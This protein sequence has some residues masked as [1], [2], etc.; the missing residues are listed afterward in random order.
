MFMRT[1]TFA[2]VGLLA[3]A[4][5]LTACGDADDPTV[6]S[7]DD[8]ASASQAQFND[9]DVA[10]VSGMVPHHTQ[11]VEM[12]DMILEQDSS[13]PVAVLA[14]KIKSAQQPEID[15]LESMLETFGEEAASAGGHGGGHGGGS[16][17]PEHAGMMSETQMQQ[18]EQ[19]SGVEAERMFLTMMIEHHRGAIQAADTELA[20]GEHPPA[21]ELANKIRD[22]QAAEIAEMEQL[23]SQL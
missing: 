14:N 7:T 11:A 12:A 17:E 2:L 8:G 9:A 18:L 4:L 20:D 22:D 16:T 10:F 6:A 3:G 5:F 15:Q 19:V 13:E 1:R 23:L 21:Q